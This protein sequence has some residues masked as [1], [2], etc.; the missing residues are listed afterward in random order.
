MPDHSLAPLLPLGGATPRRDTFAGLTITENPDV[1]IASVACRMG[2]DA[3]LAKAAAALFGTALPVPGQMVAKGDWAL[4]WTGPGQWMATAP[5]ATH[6][7]ISRIVKAGLGDTASVTEQTDAWVR[8]DIDGA[9]APDMF[10]RLCILDTRRM[11]AGSANRTMI[12]HLGTFVLCHRAGEAF[13]VLG[14]R[15][16]AASLHHAL[17]AAAKS[18]I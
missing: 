1:A 13:S 2:R 17:V 9:R 7:D 16:A 4:F 6:E 12:E 15:S 18:A 11:A 10:E 8:F 3:D 14:P 5:F